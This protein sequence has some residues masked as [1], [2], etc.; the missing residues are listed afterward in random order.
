MTNYNL[1]EQDYLVIVNIINTLNLPIFLH[2]GTLLG[3]VR[4]GYFI[5]GDNDLDFGIIRK[6][7]S[8]KTQVVMTNKLQSLGFIFKGYECIAFLQKLESNFVS[9]V[10]KFEGKFSKCNIDFWIFEERKNDYYHRGW[11][12]YFYYRKEYIDILDK[13][14]FLEKEIYIPHNSESFLE[15]MYGTNWR[16]PKHF[17][18]E[19]KSMCYSNWSKE[20]KN[21]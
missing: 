4:E 16:I 15:N 5:N 2:A 7:F 8:L 1:L 14:I 10:L 20:L 12:G 11:L 19:D 9:Y 6:H 3:Y 17:N 21:E 13:V 18:C